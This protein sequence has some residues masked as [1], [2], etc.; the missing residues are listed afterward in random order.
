MADIVGVRYK[1]AGRIYYFDPAGIDLGVGDYVVVE[2][3]RGLE[4]G[5]VVLA[6][7]QVL[8]GEITEPLKTVVRKAMEEDIKRAQELEGKKIEVL[9]ECAGLVCDLKLPMKLIDADLNL[10]DNRLTV[11]FSAEGRVDFRELVRELSRRLKMRVELRQVGPRDAAKMVGGFGRCGREL[12]CQGFITEFKPV[13]IKMAKEQDMPLNPM[14]ISGVCGRLL[15]CLGYEYE[16]YRSIK[17]KLPRKGQPVSTPEGMATVI[18][19][20]PLKEM[21]LVELKD[22][23]SIEVP[24]S[25]VTLEIA[26]APGQEAGQKKD[27]RS[28]RKRR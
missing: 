16:Q 3:S 11:Y 22:G 1:R 18:G 5:W 28:K 12:C 21:V 2:T 23:V 17:Q 13:S 9:A 25:E 4:L 19:S 6:P 7:T 27:T 24:L 20:D 10:D 8:A 15:C 14:K 26:A